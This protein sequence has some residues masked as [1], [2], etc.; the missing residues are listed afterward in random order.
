MQTVFCLSDTSYNIMEVTNELKRTVWNKGQVVEGFNPD[1]YRKDACG[2][3][4]IWDK[5]GMDDNIYG[6]EIDHI[7][8]KSRLEKRGLKEPQISDIRNLRPLQHQNNASKADD[9]PSY[10]AVVISKGNENILQ[11]KNFT[12]NEVVRDGLRELYQL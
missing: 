6:W 2:A 7:Y 10:T 1:M 12:V 11:N 3:W 4:I 9:Y 8:P 5:Y